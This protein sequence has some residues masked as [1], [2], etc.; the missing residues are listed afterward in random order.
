M[1]VPLPGTAVLNEPNSKLGNA[2]CEIVGFYARMCPLLVALLLLLSTR[3]S[4]SSKR[5]QLPNQSPCC[6]LAAMARSPSWFAQRFASQRKYEP[7]L[8]GRG[9]I[10]PTALSPWAGPPLSPS[11]IRIM[12][13]Q[14]RWRHLYVN[15]PNENGTRSSDPLIDFHKGKGL[16]LVVLDH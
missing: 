1:D 13:L 6:T 4:S 11:T 14:Q 2:V 10:M 8:Q 16:L 3:Y 5:A 9:N 12:Q 7:L 15:H